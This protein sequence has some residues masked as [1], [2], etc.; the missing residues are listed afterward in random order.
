MSALVQSTYLELLYAAAPEL[1][2]AKPKVAEE[3]DDLPAGIV[4]VTEAQQAAS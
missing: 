1:R 4:T 2:V 3:D